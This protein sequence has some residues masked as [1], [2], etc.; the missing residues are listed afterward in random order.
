M[1]N[2]MGP[3]VTVFFVAV[4]FHIQGD[5]IRYEVYLFQY[6]AVLYLILYFRLIHTGHVYR[7]VKFSTCNNRC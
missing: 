7:R 6:T 1:I 5:Q 3:H 4:K 2:N